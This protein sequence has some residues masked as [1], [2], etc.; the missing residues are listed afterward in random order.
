MESQSPNG[1]TFQKTLKIK[2]NPA[3]TEISQN[4]GR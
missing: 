2:E 4:S 1:K 3:G